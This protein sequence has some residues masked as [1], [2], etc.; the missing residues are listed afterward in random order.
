[1]TNQLHHD[2]ARAIFS[3]DRA[4]G[5]A[6]VSSERAPACYVATERDPISAAIR[7]PSAD[8]FPRRLDSHAHYSF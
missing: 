5:H 3:L 4:H 6:P 8:N 2:L 7:K 1:M